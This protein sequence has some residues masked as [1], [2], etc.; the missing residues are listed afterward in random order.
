M[1]AEVGERGLKVWAKQPGRRTNKGGTDIF[2]EQT[3]NRVYERKMFNHARKVLD[4]GDDLRGPS[5]DEGEKVSEYGL[6]GL[7]KYRI[8]YDHLHTD[9][10]DQVTYHGI[11]CKWLGRLNHKGVVDVPRGVL[12][13][14]RSLFYNLEDPH[15][16]RETRASTM[17][18]GYT[19]FNDLDGTNYRVHPNYS[20]SGPWYDWA[21]IKCPHNNTDLMK[22]N[23][24]RPLLPDSGKPMKRES[25]SRSGK[26]KKN[27]LVA[28]YCESKYGPGHVPAKVI[29]LYMCPNDH[30]PKALVHACRPWMQMNYKKSSTIL[31]CWHLQHRQE[32][33]YKIVGKSRQRRKCIRLRPE[34]SSI[35]ADSLLERIVVF[36]ETPGI[37]ETIDDDIYSGHVIFVTDRKSYWPQQFFDQDG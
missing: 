10:T 19:E 32:E 31:K 15:S 9:T 29:A 36:E 27:V 35:L 18:E 7:P 13:G 17:V 12:E 1:D 11:V 8:T 25:T 2:T 37:H 20:N 33:A 14:F 23:L 28:S 4:S 6:V 22:T 26:G 24:L 5:D 34:Y 16:T 21:I 30:V 3:A